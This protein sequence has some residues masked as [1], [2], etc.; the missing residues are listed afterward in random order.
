MRKVQQSPANLH[1]H[2]VEQQVL[3]SLS[4]PQQPEIVKRSAQELD[5]SG[6][7]VTNELITDHKYDI[8]SFPEEIKPIVDIVLRVIKHQTAGT[9]GVNSQRIWSQGLPGLLR[10][11]YG[12]QCQSNKDPETIATVTSAPQRIQQSATHASAHLQPSDLTTTVKIA[13]QEV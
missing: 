8:S 2:T 4:N 5:V 7:Q 13:A 10:K 6:N 11:R 1:K 12:A 9:P 3:A